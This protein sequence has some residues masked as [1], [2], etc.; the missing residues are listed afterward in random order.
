MFL[1][2]KHHNTVKFL[3]GISIQGV[4]SF[5][6]KAWGGRASNRF[7]TETSGFLL[8]LLPGDL[9]LADRG[10]DIQDSAILHYA[11]VKI[12]D[13]R[14]GKQQMLSLEVERS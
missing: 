14:K 3:I 5:M 12:P 8:N 2:Y 13:F 11:K 4:V 7:I 6:S 1:V 9:I 10:F